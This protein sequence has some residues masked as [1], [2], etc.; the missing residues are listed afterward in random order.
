MKKRLAIGAL[1]TASLFGGGLLAHH[2]W[3]DGIPGGAEPS[4]Y[5]SGFL[6]DEAGP[7]NGTP[8]IRVSLW[9]REASGTGTE[10]C[11]S[12][13]SPVT[14][15]EGNFRVGLPSSCVR[16]VQESA[17]VYTE[18]QIGTDLPLPRQ[19]LGAVPYAVEAAN[20]VPPGTIVA[21]G[22]GTVPDGWAL[23]DGTPVSGA[24][25]SPHRRLFLAVG[26]TWG[27]G[28]DGSGAMFSLP[29]LRGRFLRG[30]DEGA[31]RDP[32]GRV[33]IQPGGSTSGVGTAQTDALQ[34][35]TGSLAGVTFSA[36]AGCTS[37]TGV[38]NF[39]L[40]GFSAYQAGTN[41]R[42]TSTM[43]FDASR[44]ART[45]NET[46]PMNAAVAFIVKL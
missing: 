24:E 5:Y 38:F 35:M 32:G 41:A 13:R 9:D 2:A 20:G 15:T 27:D 39:T 22:G 37:A 30:D 28:G 16:A 8:A 12:A 14:V 11:A 36:C 40:G 43:Y 1:C 10:L 17:N 29:D 7:V 46:R 25:G 6:E 31:G 18:V 19:H 45:S 23:C 44:S 3:A 26:E 33:A 21:F 34:N 4:M 42:T